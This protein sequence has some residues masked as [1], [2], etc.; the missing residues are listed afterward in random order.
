M[1][2]LLA[3]FA[4]AALGLSLASLAGAADHHATTP[5]ACAA[6]S[7]CQEIVYKEVIKKVCRQ[8]PDVKKV[9]KWVYDCK[10]ED[11]CIKQCSGLL[12]KGGSGCSSGCST[13]CDSGCPNGTCSGPYQRTLL[14]KRLVTT[15]VP[16]TK[17]IVE[18]VVERVPCVVKKAPCATG[19]CR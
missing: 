12:G 17:C 16:T 1:R 7:P 2:S 14:I 5:A 15:E 6:C 10:T 9:T 3:S 8:V 4:L 18:E 13:G 19:S 11:F